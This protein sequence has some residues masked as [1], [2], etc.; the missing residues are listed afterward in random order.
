MICVKGKF[1]WGYINLDQWLIK[2]LVRKNGEFYEVEWDEVLNVIVDNFIF[3]K[4]KYG[5]DVLLFI[6]FFKV[7]NEELYLM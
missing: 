5:L 7:M 6:F 3:I 4:E 1:L 2:L